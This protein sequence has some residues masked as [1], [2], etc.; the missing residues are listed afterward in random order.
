MSAFASQLAKI[1][2]RVETL[3]ARA[4]E[5]A[6]VNQQLVTWVGDV[7]SVRTLQTIGADGRADPAPNVRRT[8]ELK[9]VNKMNSDQKVVINGATMH[10]VLANETLLVPVPVG[11][12]TTQI[13]GKGPISWFIGPQNYTQEVIIAPAA[14]IRCTKRA[15]A[16]NSPWVRSRN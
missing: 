3:E 15:P 16:S 10:T 11:A 12:V 2:K 14:Q 5:Q 1:E 7:G 9:I 6:A 4:S 13:S 8:G